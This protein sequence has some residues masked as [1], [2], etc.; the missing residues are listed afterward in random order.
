MLFAWCS[1]FRNQYLISTN[2]RKNFNSSSVDVFRSTVNH[3]QTRSSGVKAFGIC[4]L[5][6]RSSS[7]YEITWNKSCQLYRETSFSGQAKKPTQNDEKVSFD[8]F[9]KIHIVADG[10]SYLKKNKTRAIIDSQLVQLSLKEEITNCKQTPIYGK[11][12]FIFRSSVETS[13]GR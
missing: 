7:V 13:N 11:R 4:H 3:A 12:N 1:K 6:L 10:S 2:P 9:Y 5:R 8:P